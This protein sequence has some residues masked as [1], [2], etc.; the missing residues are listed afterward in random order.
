MS[1]TDWSH[2]RRMWRGMKI[3]PKLLFD[4][5]IEA[6]KYLSS[7]DCHPLESLTELLEISLLTS[8]NIQSFPLDLKDEEF[9][10]L[11]NELGEIVEMLRDASNRL[12]RLS[13]AIARSTQDWE[14]KW[15]ISN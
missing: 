8:E 5:R 10:H 14:R 15:H 1:L 3:L 6:E 13:S 9:V 2:G 11:R 12:D 7:A 4:K